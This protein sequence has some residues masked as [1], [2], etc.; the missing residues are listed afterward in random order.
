MCLACPFFQYLHFRSLFARQG[1]S[2]R[3][4]VA[5][6]RRPNS[7]LPLQLKVGEYFSFSHFLW[8]LTCH[9]PFTRQNVSTPRSIAFIWCHPSFVPFHST[10]CECSS[11]LSFGVFTCL[12]SFCLTVC[13]CPHW[14]SFFQCPKVSFCPSQQLV[15]AMSLAYSLLLYPELSLPL[16]F[17][18]G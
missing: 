9:S 8:F 5:F 1:V 6:I 14:L 2:A 10:V 12:P 3:C 13:E 15:G 4:L 7:S 17:T 18:A 16:H 11:S